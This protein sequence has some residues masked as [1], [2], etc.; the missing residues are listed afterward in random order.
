MEDNTRNYIDHEASALDQNILDIDTKEISK[1]F[2]SNVFIWMFAALLISG[3]VSYFFANSSLFEVLMRGGKLV[4]YAVMFA[5]LG[6][7]IALGA[8]YKRFSYGMLALLFLL[9]SIVMGV[10]FSY[11]F[12][13]YKPETITTIFFASAGLFGTMA[14]VGYRTTTD[15]TK[16]GSYLMM[17]LIG[18]IIV[19]VI[20]IFFVNSEPLD[21][22]L[23]YVGVLIFVGLTAYD[24][25]KIKM[26]AASVDVNEEESKKMMLFGGLSLYLD[27]INI[28]LLLLRLFGGR[29]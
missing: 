22:V 13:I 7:V 27:F 10:S 16:M 4:N 12:H 17:A 23:G 21:Y 1:T 15:L 9:F 24:M 6:F 29:D 8:G 11:I 20:N 18:M 19:S 2:I 28:F 25:Q 3:G 14:F 26:M 5:P